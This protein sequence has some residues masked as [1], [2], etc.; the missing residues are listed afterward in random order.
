MF[1]HVNHC[2]Q[3]I[4]AGAV[5]PAVTY[6]HLT[7]KDGYDDSRTKLGQYSNGFWFQDET[8]R[9]PFLKQS[10]LGVYKSPSLNGK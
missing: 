5:V 9:F 10:Y 1:K 4:V 8:Y 7:L 3:G 2:Q 6:C